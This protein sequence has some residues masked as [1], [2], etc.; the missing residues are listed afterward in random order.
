MKPKILILIIFSQAYINFNCSFFVTEVFDAY[1]KEELTP[2]EIDAIDIFTDKSTTSL[3]FVF[4]QQGDSIR[5]GGS[6]FEYLAKNHGPD[7]K[8]S[9]FPLDLTDEEQENQPTMIYASE[10]TCCWYELICLVNKNDQNSKAVTL[11]NNLAHSS[12][13]FKN[14]NPLSN[15]NNPAA[16][17]T[18]T[19]SQQ[20]SMQKFKQKGFDKNF[21]HNLTQSTSNNLTIAAID[22][23]LRQPSTQSFKQKNLYEEID[24]N[25]AREAS[26]NSITTVAA[27]ILQLPS[28]QSFKQKNLGKK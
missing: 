7:Y 24:D 27:R 25:P 5:Q 20:L 22:R 21:G 11:P 1:P 14:Q 15:N 8:P 12:P 28:T 9:L 26:D 13:A 3:C 23:I 6:K 19:I 2:E 16:S 17:I 10:I 4:I 18:T